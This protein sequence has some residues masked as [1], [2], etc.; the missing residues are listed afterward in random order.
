MATLEA[1]EYKPFEAIKEIDENGKEFWRARDLQVVLEYIEW[2]NF[3]KVI[4]KAMLACENAKHPV[5]EHFVDVNKMVMLGSN[6][7]KIIPDYKLTRY[8]CYLIVQNGNPRKNVIA[9]GQTYFA[10]QTRRAE[11]A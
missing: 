9:L 11:V 8:A 10:I 4:D 6:T 2:R 1:L 7:Q 5:V 3:N